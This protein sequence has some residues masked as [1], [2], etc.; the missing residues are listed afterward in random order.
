MKLIKPSY[1]ITTKFDG[2]EVLR[3][4]E[5][6]GRTAYKS[7][8]KITIKSAPEFIL[9]IIDREHEAVLEFFDITFKWICDRGV[10]HEL[11]RHR[12][13][14]YL[15]ES[16]RYCNYKGGI[17]FV[18]PP[19]VD[20]LPDDYCGEGESITYQETG[21]PLSMPF[22][23]PE[24]VWIQ[25]MLNTEIS[26][27][28]LLKEGWKPQQARSV[29]PNSLKTEINFKM[30]LRELRHFFKLRTHHT[31]HPQMREL[32]IPM[33]KELKIKLPII[34]DDIEME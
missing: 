13:A 1:E 17:T 20:I 22:L 9:K 28:K 5:K 26:Y 10:S 15:Q 27:R 11:V 32:A 31:A 2:K 8:D 7:E 3:V 12:I 21:N 18:I 14:S 30:N 6:I 34:F 25:S 23:Y 19:W 24:S 16:T 29:L 4:L 33:L